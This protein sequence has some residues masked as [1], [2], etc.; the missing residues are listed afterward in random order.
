M[1]IAE[2]KR[3]LLLSPHTD[4]V[5]LAAGGTVARFVEEG[6]EVF[7]VAFSIA[8]KSVP[9][10][11]PENI[12]ETECQQATKTLGIPSQNL[13]IHKFP[14]RE[15][16]GF[17]QD[18]LEILIS[19]KNT[20]QPDLVL[21]PSLKDIHQD[22][23]TIAME[24]SRAFRYTSILAYELSW[25][26]FHFDVSCLIALEDR[27][28]AKKV[29]AIKCYQ[30]QKSRPG[31]SSPGVEEDFIYSVAR[32]W[33]AQTNTRYAEAFEVVRWIIK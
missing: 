15:L 29:A 14:V 25:N 31:G 1:N 19:Y 10:G 2:V 5:E 20:L 6:K 16:P 11:L 22:H 17:R 8:E 30:S 4:D 3:V 26:L 21:L 32:T 28:M 33:G 7:Y 18:I 27:F 13:F 9:E 24:G 12:L 23:H